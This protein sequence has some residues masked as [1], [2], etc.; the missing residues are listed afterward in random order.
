MNGAWRGEE[1]VRIGKDAEERVVVSFIL[2]RWEV[3]RENVSCAAVDYEAR[4][5]VCVGFGFLV[6]HCFNVPILK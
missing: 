1:V 6:F 4:C 5:Y 3:G 2:C